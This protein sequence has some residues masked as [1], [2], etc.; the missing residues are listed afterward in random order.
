VL[1]ST[2]VLGGVN[3]NIVAYT[4]KAFRDANPKTVKA[5]LD[6]LDEASGTVA[7]DRNQAAA[8]YLQT[9]RDKIPIDELIEILGDPALRYSLAP[10]GTMMFAEFMYKTGS[11]KVK[12]AGWKDLFFEEA[13]HL[14]GS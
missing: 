10:S 5:Y 9:S 8:L 1:R 2:D 7:H 14:P 12:P 4:T 3:T 11:I 13:H 6:A